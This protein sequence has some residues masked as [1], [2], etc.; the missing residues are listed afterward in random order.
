MHFYDFMHDELYCEDISVQKIA[1]SIETPF[2]LYSQKAILENFNRIDTAFREVDHLICYALK[3]NSNLTLLSILAQQG[4]GADVV[5]AGEIYL[6][7]KSGIPPEKIVYAGVG[8]KDDEIRYALERGIL[9]FNMESIQEL[10]VINE[11]AK[12][13]QKKA[14]ISLRINPNIDI[15]G[16]PYISTGKLADKFGIEIPKVKQILYKLEEFSNIELMGLHCHIGSQITETKPYLKV[17]HLLNELVGEIHSIGIHLKHVDI[18]GG[19]G[20]R[21]ENVFQE[22]QKSTTMD[23]ERILTPENLVSSL[24]PNLKQMSCKIIFE[25]GRVLV[26]EAGVLVTKVLFRKENQGKQ[27]IIVDA[28][29]N[30]LIRPSLYGAYH[31]IVP[32]KKNTNE[33]LEE[34][35]VVGP[36]CESGDFLAKDTWL[37]EVQRGDL[38]VVMTTGAYGFSLSSNY[39]ARLRPVEVLVNGDKFQIIR[40]R[41]KLE[42]LWS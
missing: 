2:Y 33:M 16:H 18:G 42:N 34:V 7:L 32:V 14:P 29:M 8:K 23:S 1:E 15:H 38:L 12:S 25:P 37:P 39:N 20:V 6:A 13:L 35:D 19:L 24:L 4:S 36:I 17:A 27:F 40:E 26:A 30:D 5:S 9:A 10:S 3:A 28:G 31:E 11:I 41:G 22:N 21:Y